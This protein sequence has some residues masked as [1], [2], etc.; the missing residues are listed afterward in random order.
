[1]RKLKEQIDDY[2]L[3]IDAAI[4]ACMRRRQLVFKYYEMKDSHQKS[5]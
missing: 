5:A 4:D 2:K 1:V 3:M